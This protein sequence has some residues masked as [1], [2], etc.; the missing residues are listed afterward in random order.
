MNRQF[1]LSWN[2]GDFIG[3]FAR[4]I[5]AADEKRPQA[6]G[7]GGRLFAP[8]IGPHTEDDTVRFVMDEL[9]ISEPTR[10]HNYSLGVPYP[11]DSRNKCDLCFGDGYSWMWAIEFKM[12]RMLGDNGKPN[13]NMLNHILSPYPDHRSAVTD[14]EKLSRF[15]LAEVAALV[16]FGYESGPFPLEPAIAAFEALASRKVALGTRVQCAF[17]DLV[18]PVHRAGMVF[19]WEV[20]LQG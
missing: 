11:G 10:Y 6:S 3:S 13:D 18:H 15:R 9:A 17:R 7:R 14:C 5:Q 8:G 12:L 20:P 1:G 19:G 2:I 4:G 16:I